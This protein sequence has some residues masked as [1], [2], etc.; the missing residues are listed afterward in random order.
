MTA[1]Q[2]LGP[3]PE[4]TLNS[5]CTVTFEA[6]DPGTGADVSG[7]VVSLAAL[8][9]VN[10]TDDTFAGIPDNVGAQ[11]LYVVVSQPDES[12]AP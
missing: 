1:H 6:I 5:G 7:V 11:P 10:T 2:L 12:T 9:G 4:V 3:L 8:Y